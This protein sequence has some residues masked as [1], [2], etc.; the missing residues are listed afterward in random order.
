M[1]GYF[2]EFVRWVGDTTSLVVSY[3][4]GLLIG[5]EESDQSSIVETSSHKQVD[6]VN[7]VNEVTVS[8]T[9]SSLEGVVKSYIVEVEKPTDPI[10]FMRLVKPKVLSETGLNERLRFT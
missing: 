8:E 7:E 10:S 1:S 3:V 2:T 4:R 9:T 6:E 5:D